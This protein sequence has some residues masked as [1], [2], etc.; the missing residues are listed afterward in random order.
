VAVREETKA[1]C[2]ASKARSILRARRVSQA[3]YGNHLPGEPAGNSRFFRDVSTQWRGNP[4]SEQTQQ[5]M[6]GVREGEQP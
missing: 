6:I 3:S 4:M 2:L 1:E 5:T